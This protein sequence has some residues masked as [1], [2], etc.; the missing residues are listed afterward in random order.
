LENYL[1][2]GIEKKKTF[3]KNRGGWLKGRCRSWQFR[4]REMKIGEPIRFLSNEGTEQCH[5]EREE[6]PI[7]AEKGSNKPVVVGTKVSPKFYI[8]PRS[9]KKKEKGARARRG[10]LGRRLFKQKRI[11]LVGK[12]WRD[13]KKPGRSGRLRKNKN[14]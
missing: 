13:Q 2:E 7:W 9:K 14:R 6:T 5:L 4:G 3:A 8:R 1:R 12:S 11:T 10:L